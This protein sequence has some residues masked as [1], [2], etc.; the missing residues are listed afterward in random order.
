MDLFICYLPFNIKEI[1]SSTRYQLGGA[2][3]AFVHEV[4]LCLL[5]W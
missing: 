4:L 5:V 3:D 1:V 2:P